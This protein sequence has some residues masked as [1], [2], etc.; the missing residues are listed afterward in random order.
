MGCSPRGCGGF[1]SARVGLVSVHGMWI[2]I[3]EASSGATNT[4]MYVSGF[5]SQSSCDM[6]YITTDV[7]MFMG[8]S[9][10]HNYM[11]LFH[12]DNDIKGRS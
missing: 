10:E 2:S 5:V 1:L 8:V 9:L 11:A 12:M 7:S 3:T 4:D 6:G